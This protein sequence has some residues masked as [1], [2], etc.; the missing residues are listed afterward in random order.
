MSDDERHIMQQHVQYWN[1]L[2]SKGNVLAFGP[3]LDP[4]GVYGI[5]IVEAEDEEQV[6]TFIANDP[7]NGLNDYEYHSMLAVTPQH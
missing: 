2:M 6:K 7:A 4:C 3:V 1:D 5:G